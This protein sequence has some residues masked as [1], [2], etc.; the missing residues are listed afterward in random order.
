MVG[1]W[2]SAARSLLVMTL[3]EWRRFVT[4][5]VLIRGPFRRQIRKKPGGTEQ[6]AGAFSLGT[7]WEK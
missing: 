4:T 6:L 1:L 2:A 7:L 5:N 3:P